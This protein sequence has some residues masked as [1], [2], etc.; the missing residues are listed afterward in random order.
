MNTLRIK[1]RVM[2]IPNT[3]GLLNRA[4]CKLAIPK[5]FIDLG[6]G[7]RQG[8]RAVALRLGKVVELSRC[9]ALRRSYTMKAVEFLLLS[10]TSGRGAALRRSYTM[11]S[12]E[13]L[14][15]SSTSKA[16]A[17]LAKPAALVCKTAARFRKVAALLP[18]VPAYALHTKVTGGPEIFI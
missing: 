8:D 1:Q 7:S 10:S 18:R 16:T 11:K 14:L 13:F 15:I 12:P 2:R 17:T 6:R 9:P 4:A 3:R 5:T